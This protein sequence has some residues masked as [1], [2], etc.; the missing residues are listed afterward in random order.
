MPLNIFGRLTSRFKTESLRELR[1][2]VEG[3]SAYRPTLPGEELLAEFE[4][5]ASSLEDRVLLGML[6]VV[7]R[8]AEIYGKSAEYEALERQGIEEIKKAG[9]APA[10]P[11]Q[12]VSQPDRQGRIK[13]P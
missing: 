3:R 8:R 9:K 5:P 13:P 7:K 12:K 10:T 11:T 4:S 6:R 1:D 2:S